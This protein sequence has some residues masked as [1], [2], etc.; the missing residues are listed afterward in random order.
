MEVK[1]LK[2]K[3]GM[4]IIFRID[5]RSQKIDTFSPKREVLQ[6]PLVKLGDPRPF[7]P[8][9]LIPRSLLYLHVFRD[10]IHQTVEYD[11]W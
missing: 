1:D 3:W 7:V 6:Y 10:L 5:S 11:V 9:F 8:I 2:K 4:G